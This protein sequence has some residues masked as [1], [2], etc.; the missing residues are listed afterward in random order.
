MAN[1]TSNYSLI[2]LTSIAKTSTGWEPK[3]GCNIRRRHRLISS[4][5]RGGRPRLAWSLLAI[6]TLR[7]CDSNSAVDVINRGDRQRGH[8]NQEPPALAKLINTLKSGKIK[9]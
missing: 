4:A 9:P 7:R 3:C 6:R 1:A 5:S 2:C 8:L